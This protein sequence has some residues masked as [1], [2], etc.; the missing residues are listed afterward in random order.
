MYIFC[1]IFFSFQS[2]VIIFFFHSTRS[3]CLCVSFN[4][5]VFFL[6][7]RSLLN[8]CILSYIHTY[9]HYSTKHNETLTRSVHS[10]EWTKH[11]ETPLTSCPYLQLNKDLL[12]TNH[13]ENSSQKEKTAKK[14]KKIE[15]KLKGKTAKH[16][17]KQEKTEKIDLWQ[18]NEKLRNS[19]RF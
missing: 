9:I 7:L 12:W 18:L 6:S 10:G 4:M 11:F 3:V 15:R 17:E 1:F 8:T 16:V 5:C 14:G 2:H 13:Y 19:L